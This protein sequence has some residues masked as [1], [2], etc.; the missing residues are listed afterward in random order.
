MSLRSRTLGLAL[1]VGLC[2]APAAVASPT[3]LTLSVTA[4]AH[5]PAELTLVSRLG[6][7]ERGRSVAFF[8]VSTE[9]GPPRNVPIGTAATAAN[10]TASIGYRPTWSGEEQ[11]VAELTGPGARV[12]PAT[13]SY[14]VTA[15]TPGL[16]SVG[17][18]PARPLASVGRVFLAVIL[19][20]VALVWL[21][22]I[23]TLVLAIG[24]MPRLAGR[25]VD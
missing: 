14:R 21:G 15:S 16:L 20:V 17:A 23:I 1:A 6:S 8:V 10:G 22:L 9:F 18:N 2:S 13:A 25:G 3:G 5:H 19:T 24:W 7:G 4:R 12:P 11:F